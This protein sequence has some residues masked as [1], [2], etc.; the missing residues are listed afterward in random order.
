MHV[1]VR[2]CVQR[3]RTHRQHNQEVSLVHVLVQY[4]VVHAIILVRP[5]HIQ[6]P[7][8]VIIQITPVRPRAPHVRGVPVWD[9]QREPVPGGRVI[10]HVR[11]GRIGMVH[12]ALRVEMVIIAQVSK[13]LW[14]LH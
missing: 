12:H 8:M 6:I 10:S 1:I 11:R 7:V 5:V 4:R 13:M 14:N 2:R 3:L 9:V